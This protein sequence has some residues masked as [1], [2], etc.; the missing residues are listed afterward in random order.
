[1]TPLTKGLLI[2][3]IQVAIVSSLGAKLLVDRATRPRIWV[4][5]APVDPNLPIRGRYVRMRIEAVPSGDAIVGNQPW[6]RVSVL[7]SERRGQL[8]ATPDPSGSSHV[9]VQP[10]TRAGENREAVVVLIEP[11][12]YF[13]PEHAADPSSRSPGEELWVEVTVPRAGLPRPIRLGVKKDGVLTPI[14]VS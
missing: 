6:N 13:I 5:A 7:L 3:A 9:W 10:T 12:A 8:V 11:V 4:R 2:G 14:N 1:M